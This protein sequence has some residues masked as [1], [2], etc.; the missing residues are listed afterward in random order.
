MENNKC[1]YVHKD[2][3]GIVR[4]VGSGTL[5][6]ANQTYAKSNRGEN[7]KEYV[8]KCGKLD[9]EIVYSGISTFEAIKLPRRQGRRDRLRRHHRQ[10]R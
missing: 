10:H 3:D 9:V 8:N 4:Y 1:V 2:A 5:Q 7:Y 6:R